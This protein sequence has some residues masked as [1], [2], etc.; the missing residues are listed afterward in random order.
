MVFFG[1]SFS[2]LAIIQISSYLIGQADLSSPE[3][4]LN[5]TDFLFSLV[6]IIC[7]T[8]F[9]R[10]KPFG[11]LTTL[12]MLYLGCTLFAGLFIVLILQPWITG[13]PLAV[14]DLALLAVMSLVVVL[15][16]RIFIRVL[17]NKDH[18]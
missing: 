9:W 1:I 10:R 14:F 3:I 2:T 16:F 5:I 15:P 8:A 4:A 18:A 12:G 6:W 7:G 17:R 11:Y 13:E